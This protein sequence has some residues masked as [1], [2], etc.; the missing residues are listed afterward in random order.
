MIQSLHLQNF[1]CFTD[2]EFHFS[3]GINVFIGENG[4]GKTHLLKVLAAV[5]RNNAKEGAEDDGTYSLIGDRN[6]FVS[7][8]PK[9]FNCQ[10]NDL[11]NRLGEEAIVNCVVKPEKKL[12]FKWQKNRKSDNFV[13]NS[14][15][16]T[17][18]IKSLFVPSREMLSFVRGFISIYD[19]YDWDFDRTYYLLA[20][21][22]DIP[23]LHEDF[24][25]KTGLL[26][27]IAD[28]KDVLGGAEVVK[29]NGHF[30]L[31]TNESKTE[32]NLVAEGWR[33][34]ATLIY[35]ILNGE[36]ELSKNS[37]LFID[38]PEANLNPKLIETMARFLVKIAN[39]GVQIFIASHDYLLCN[40]LSV[41]SENKAFFEK[42]KEHISD[43][44]FF[45]LHK[46]DD[47]EG[48]SIEASHSLLGLETA[49][50]S[51]F[52]RFYKNERN[53]SHENLK[54]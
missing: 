30:Y 14:K 32:I 21:H 40:Y 48:I 33:K 9:F 46:K 10:P 34:I 2:N 36:L 4:T 31:K 17:H 28:L 3:E 18:P 29:E 11:I 19:K 12:F 5:L 20:K 7:A 44:K 52:S 25:K 47:N 8:L 39:K 45:S 53:W 1:T 22:L 37:V 49:I 27:L 54:I 51:E 13:S 6:I 26:D 42:K 43:I 16:L 15:P 24:I 41:F 35:L 38:E 23:L 50:M